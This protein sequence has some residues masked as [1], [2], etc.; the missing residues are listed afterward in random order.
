VADLPDADEPVF[1][2]SHT[3][4]VRGGGW[5]QDAKRCRL[6]SRQRVLRA[7]RHVAIGFRVARNVPL[8]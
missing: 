7:S 1:S 6:A 3:A 5:N 8:R 2:D 4:P